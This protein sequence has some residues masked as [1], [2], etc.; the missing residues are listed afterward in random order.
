MGGAEEVGL[1]KKA[2]QSG[3]RDAA[4]RYLLQAIDID[5]WNEQA[6]LWLSTVIDDP[7]RERECLERALRLAHNHHGARERS[8]AAQPGGPARRI[9]DAATA[10]KRTWLKVRTPRHVLALGV[11]GALLCTVIVWMIWRGNQSDVATARSARLRC[12]A[13]VRAKLVA[14]ST[15]QFSSPSD[16]AI[17]RTSDE[18]DTWIVAGHVDAQNVYSAMLRRRYVCKVRYR[19]AG[20][21]E[22]IELYVQE[23]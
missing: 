6:W 23:P 20:E 13:Y 9:A 8:K 17:G 2:I 10:A 1:A 7:D 5:P 14:P 22:L 16:M 18:G 21:W 15:A 12:E 3:D 4:R 19:G 11:I